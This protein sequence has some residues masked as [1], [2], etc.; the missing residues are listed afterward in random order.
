MKGSMR[1]YLYFFIICFVLSAPAFAQTAAELEVLLNTNAVSYEQAARFV[2]EAADVPVSAGEAFRHAAEQNW[3]PQDAAPG[4]TAVL[5]GVSHLIMQSFGIKGGILY[6]G[7]Q[8]PHYAYRELVYLNVI[9]GRVDPRM[10]V[11]GEFLLFMIGRMLS[12]TEDDPW[13]EGTPMG[14][15]I[16]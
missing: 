13:P 15:G 3:L 1:K 16:E 4:D 8:S 7:T 2:L 6:S 14:G 5:Q 9:Q 12:Q 11:S 10:A